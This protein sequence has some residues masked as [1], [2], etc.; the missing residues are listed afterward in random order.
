MDGRPVAAV[1]GA[2]GRRVRVTARALVL[3]AMALTGVCAIPAAGQ[4]VDEHAVFGQASAPP[5]AATGR[6]YRADAWPRPLPSQPLPPGGA[7]FA[8]HPGEDLQA[9]LA[10]LP[11]GACVRLDPGVHRGPLRLTRPVTV[12]GTP[13]A[14][15]RSSGTGTTVEVRA[16]SV[17]LLGF[18]IEGSGRR[19]DTTDAAV[20]VYADHVRIEGLRV[21][22]ALFGIT[23][24][25][26]RQVRI[27]GNV[28]TGL[29]GRDLGLRGD[30]IRFWEVRDSV[31][32]DN[33]VL[34]SRDVVIWYS[35]GNQVSG[36][37]V[38]GGR[39]GVHYMYS[40]RNAAIGNTFLGNLVGIFVMYSDTVE[41]RANRLAF[42]DP[43]GGMGL[44]AKESGEL[45]ATD[46][47]FL[48]NRHG[49]Y[50]DASPLQRLH[51]N[52]LARNSFLFCETGISFHRSGENSRI[53]DNEF[54]NCGAPAR[55]DGRGD[56]LRVAWEGNRFDDYQGYDLDHDGIGDVPYELH[57]LSDRLTANREDLEFFHGTPALALLDLVGRIIPLLTP[58][59]VM[60]DPAPRVKSAFPP[61]A[62]WLVGQEAADAH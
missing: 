21:T 10:S 40:H 39:Y 42:A 17:S 25:N 52:V 53:T 13:E 60:R 35:P 16:D 22:D 48:G 6:R 34:D 7:W 29:G 11:A 54:R 18:A 47:L 36:N 46:N 41:I 32:A 9:L 43:P 55:I 56:A 12:W 44:G 58:A 1:G 31:I 20:G 38:D 24:E 3:V 26:A 61:A 37:F 62:A 14:V 4:S 5:A 45:V 23:V 8:A 19:F 33:L 51:R 50:L 28:I 30:A 27:R 49:V 15:I 2:H 57:R 59:L